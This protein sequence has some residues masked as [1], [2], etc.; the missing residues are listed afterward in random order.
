[1]VSTDGLWNQAQNYIDTG[2]GDLSCGKLIEM[3]YDR[4]EKSLKIN[5]EDKSY[6]LNDQNWP[7]EVYFAFSLYVP[8]HDVRII[9]N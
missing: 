3:T 8:G 9:S 6:S 2:L 4:R 7:D 1:M 5:F